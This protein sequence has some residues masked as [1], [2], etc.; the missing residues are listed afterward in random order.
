MTEQGR[1]E[2]EMVWKEERTWPGDD[3]VRDRKGSVWKV[4]GGCHK[5]LIMMEKRT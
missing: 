5:E 2:P 4:L 1:E 3:A